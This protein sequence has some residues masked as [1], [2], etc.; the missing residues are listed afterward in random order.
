MADVA[1]RIGLAALAAVVAAGMAVQLHARG[2]LQ[3]AVDEAKREARG[4]RSA[5]AHAQAV[6]HALRV[7]D[8]RPGTAGLFVAI[9]L[10]VGARRN[11][12]AERF[13]LR[14]ARREPDNFSTWLTLGILRQRRGDRAGAE[15]AFA[16]VRRLNPL[17]PTPR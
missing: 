4:S 13:A 3:S 17:Y 6:D 2:Q 1:A 12:E 16:R 11:A 9:G 15:A 5:S 7:T 10:E 14:A 8:L